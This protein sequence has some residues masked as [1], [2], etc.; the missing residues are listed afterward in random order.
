MPQGKRKWSK[1]R[2]SWI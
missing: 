1:F 2:S